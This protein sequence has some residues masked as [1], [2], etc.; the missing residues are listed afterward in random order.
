MEEV[1][2][3]KHWNILALDS[4]GR[5][6]SVGLL[7]AENYRE[8]YIDTGSQHAET[9]MPAVEFLFKDS[10]ISPKSLN[11]VVCSAGPG[12]FTSLRIGMATAKGIARGADCDL[13]AVPALPLLV[14]GR[15]YWPGIV[16]PV[17]NA[18]R[19]RVY[20]AAFQN[21]KRIMDDSDIDLSQFLDALPDDESILITGPDAH[22]AEGKE[23]VIIDPLYDS[24]RGRLMI[25]MACHLYDRE[26]GGDPGD[27]G[28]IYMRRSEAE[29][30]LL[31]EDRRSV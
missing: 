1:Y 30:K 31:G 28:P 6:L 11:L 2:S 10:S 18:G 27:L 5:I 22:L 23:R 9:L 13:K 4:S 17:V 16:V 7:A 21:G 25:E 24:S 3:N 26:G 20:T 15:E 14:S 8:F 29:E 12:S 19:N